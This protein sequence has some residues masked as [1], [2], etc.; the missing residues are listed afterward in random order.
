MHQMKKEM[1]ELITYQEFAGKVLKNNQKGIT[2]SLCFA[3]HRVTTMLSRDQNFCNHR[4]KSM[5]REAGWKNVLVHGRL[6]QIAKK[7]A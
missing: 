6:R 3:N 4:L 1:F 5:V 2:W 7:V